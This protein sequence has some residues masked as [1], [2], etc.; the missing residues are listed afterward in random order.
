M[1]IKKGRFGTCPYSSIDEKVY[2][3]VGAGPRPALILE[4]ERRS[5]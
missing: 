1:K 3:H 4:K 2:L 5:K